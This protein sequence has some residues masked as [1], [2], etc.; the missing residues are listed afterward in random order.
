MFAVQG[1]AG[2]GIRELAD[3]IGTTTSPLYHHLDNQKLADAYVTMSFD[4]IN[5]R[6][7]PDIPD[8]TDALELFTNRW[9]SR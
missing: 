1:F 8:L 6:T 2:T 7:R 9:D 3:R 4:L 5:S